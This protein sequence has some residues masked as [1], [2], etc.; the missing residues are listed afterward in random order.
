MANR[1]AFL[2]TNAVA[3]RWENEVFIWHL[4][5]KTLKYGFKWSEGYHPEYDLKLFLNNGKERKIE[6]K[7]QTIYDKNDDYFA[8]EVMQKGKPS[9]LELTKSD[10]Y[11]IFKYGD[12]NKV[13][14]GVNEKGWPIYID[15]TK[16]DMENMFYD[17]SKNLED[18]NN[19]RYTLYVIKTEKIRQI[20]A[21][22]PNL[23][24]SPYNDSNQGKNKTYNIP[25]RMFVDNPVD[26]SAYLDYDE[27]ANLLNDFKLD[28]KS[29]N[30][31]FY[32]SEKG[33]EYLED[34][35]ID[36]KNIG[37]GQLSM[38]T[39]DTSSDSSS[40]SSSNG[41]T[42]KSFFKKLT[43]KIKSHKK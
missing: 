13:K 38:I 5:N 31:V 7:G 11:Y 16:L 28:V 42:I 9:G 33:K 37:N 10:Y 39:Y 23:P 2:K 25:I 21:D 20:I 17:F 24:E 40:S 6:V 18:Q 34:N 30:K 43:K 12:G 8:I 19:V 41:I 35:P 4:N 22:N 29:F 14:N 26:T 3:Q 1:I 32:A 27:Y 36:L 15:K